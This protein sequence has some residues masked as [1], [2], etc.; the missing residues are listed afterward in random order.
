MKNKTFISER[1]LL[2][3]GERGQVSG[4][5]G[6]SRAKRILAHPLCSLENRRSGS[7]FSIDDDERIERKVSQA[8]IGPVPD[9]KCSIQ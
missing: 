8:E 1:A 4:V 9:Q 6:H 7:V 2:T 5:A 3:G